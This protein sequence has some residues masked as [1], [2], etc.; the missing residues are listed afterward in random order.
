MSA[1]TIMSSK[2]QVVLPKRLRER[3]GWQAGT[4]FEVVDNRGSVT[5][6]P[7]A[8]TSSTRSIDE[9]LDALWLRSPYVGPKITDED[10]HAAVLEVAAENDR[11]R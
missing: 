10:M 1:Q 3:H 8:A 2:G 11:K 6:R 4:A 7:V 5:L 9:I